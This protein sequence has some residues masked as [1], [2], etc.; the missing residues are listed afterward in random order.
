VSSLLLLLSLL[1]SLHLTSATGNDLTDESMPEIVSFLS[2][3]PTLQTLLLDDSDLTIDGCRQL[4]QGLRTLSALRTLSVGTSQL[5][6]GCVLFLARA[7]SRIPS[8][9]LLSVDGNQICASG[10]EIIGKVLSDAGK[11]LGRKITHPP[12]LLLPPLSVSSLFL[13]QVTKTTMRM[14]RM[15][16][17]R[18]RVKILNQR[19]MVNHLSWRIS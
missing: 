2:A 17:K 14:A 15:T 1:S 9:R 10:L 11:E 7:V 18:W 12:S 8:F 5:T 3:C 19:L 4:S 13:P 6:A 16:W